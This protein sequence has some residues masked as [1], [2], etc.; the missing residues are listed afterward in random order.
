MDPAGWAPT[1]QALECGKTAVAVALA[2]PAS[3]VR[4]AFLLS[5]GHP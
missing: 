2:F 4:L 3:L 5:L 1:E